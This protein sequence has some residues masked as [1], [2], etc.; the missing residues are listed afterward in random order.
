MFT[1]LDDVFSMRCP[2]YQI[3]NMEEMTP[4]ITE[5]AHKQIRHVIAILKE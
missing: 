4:A 5:E 2:K 1:D 3:E